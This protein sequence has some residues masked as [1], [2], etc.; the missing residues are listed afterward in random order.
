MPEFELVGY[1]TE[2]VDGQKVPHLFCRHRHAIALCPRCQIP[3]SLGHGAAQRSVRDL[4]LLGQR[5]FL[6]FPSRRF[7]CEHCG[8]SFTEML[9]SVD[10]R[11]RQIRRF[12]Q[13]IHQ[14]CL[15]STR[16]QVAEEEWLHEATVLDIFKRW[17]KRT[18]KQ[19][20]A[21]AVRSLG[22]DEISLTKGQDSY[23]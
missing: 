6:H 11:R 18:R 2:Q 8:R 19:S 16:K 10:A 5:I 4:D 14:R 15:C 20:V 1:V 21:S 13:H 22:I 17:A 23:G 3:S 7:E 12:E 9:A